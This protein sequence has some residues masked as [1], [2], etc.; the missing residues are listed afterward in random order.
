MNLGSLL[1]KYKVHTDTQTQKITFIRLC[2]DTVIY[3]TTQII[4]NNKLKLP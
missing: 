4:R 3:V 2:V 1:I